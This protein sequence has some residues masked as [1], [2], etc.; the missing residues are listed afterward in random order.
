[1][2]A[3]TAAKDYPT[4]CLGALFTMRVRA[5]YFVKITNNSLFFGVTLFTMGGTRG[6]HADPTGDT[7]SPMSC[8]CKLYSRGSRF[9]TFLSTHSRLDFEKKKERN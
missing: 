8:L 3:E 4:P 1:M 5:P 2:V 7:T 9:Y 6:P